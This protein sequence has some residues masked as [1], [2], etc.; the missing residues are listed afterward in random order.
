MSLQIKYMLFCLI[1]ILFGC[2]SQKEGF[3]QTDLSKKIYEIQ[4]EICGNES[5]LKV[6]KNNRNKVSWMQDIEKMN[7]DTI[8]LIEIHCYSDE[9]IPIQHAYYSMFWNKKEAQTIH[10]Y[11]TNNGK[12]KSSIDKPQDS[13]ILYYLV[14]DWDTI[15][16][17]KGA[18]YEKPLGGDH[19]T[20]VT[21]IIIDKNNKHIECLC[22]RDFFYKNQ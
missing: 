4:K 1:I 9:I 8:Y 14:N 7:N 6:F 18:I 2:K 11:H 22:F 17:N 21:R 15:Q 5:Y 20:V 3:A 16:I 12:M 19:N 13:D 10:S